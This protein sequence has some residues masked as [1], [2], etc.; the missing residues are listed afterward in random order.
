M[1][2]RR[3]AGHPRTSYPTVLRLEIATALAP[4]GRVTPVS[5]TDRGTGFVPGG[6]LGGMF[7]SRGQND[8]S[9]RLH[10]VES[11]PGPEAS[12]T[13]GSGHI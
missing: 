5:D 9:A 8:V 11:Q 2:Y 7:L 12:S 3:F 4:P 10:V 1:K 6:Q 13:W